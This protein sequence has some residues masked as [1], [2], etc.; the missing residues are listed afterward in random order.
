MFYLDTDK[1]V[2]AVNDAESVGTGLFDG[3]PSDIDKDKFH[4][5][6]R[7]MTAET[8]EEIA[9]ISTEDVISLWEFVPRFSP[10]FEGKG[11]PLS[12]GFSILDNTKSIIRRRIL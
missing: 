7:I 12:N 5:F 4:M 9:D 11:N 6:Y 2:A 8:P 3:L 1:A 10:Y